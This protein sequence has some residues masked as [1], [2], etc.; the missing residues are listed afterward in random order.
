MIARGRMDRGM[1][2]DVA[3]EEIA[4]RI[5]RVCGHF[6]EDEFAALVDHMADIEVRYRWRADWL[7][8]V[9]DSASRKNPLLSA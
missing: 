7:S 1:A 2:L 6:N 8:F 5:K 9:G 4:R 3:R